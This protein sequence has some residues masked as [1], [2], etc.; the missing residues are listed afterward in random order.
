MQ[1][2]PCAIRIPQSAPAERDFVVSLLKFRIPE[3]FIFLQLIIFHAKE[4]FQNLG[5]FIPACSQH[6]FWTEL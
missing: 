4:I 6:Y 5:T 3:F 2:E 1:T